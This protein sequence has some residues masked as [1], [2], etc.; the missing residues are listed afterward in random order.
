MFANDFEWYTYGGLLADTAA[1]ENPGAQSVALYEQ[2]PSPPSK[3]FEPGFILEQLPTGMTRYV[4]YGAG[5]SIPSENL[6]FYFGGLRSATWGDI[7]QT[8]GPANESVNADVNSLTL[9]KLNMAV[10]QQETWNNYTLPP[11]VPGRASAEIAWVPVAEQGVLVAIGGV[12]DPAYV[13]VN[14]TNNAS[15]NAA[16][17]SIFPLL[18]SSSNKSSGSNKPWI[19]IDRI[20]V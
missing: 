8:P 9:I 1:Y 11:S 13:N 19:C 3:Q 4:T 10:Q 12:I 5:V 18:H 16:S 14:Q 17:V 7:V 15:V 2:Y 6:G 20:C